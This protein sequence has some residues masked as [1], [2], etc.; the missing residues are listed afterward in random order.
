VL[1]LFHETPK[2]MSCVCIFSA[3]V[4]SC[5]QKCCSVFKNVLQKSSTWYRIKERNRVP[6]QYWKCWLVKLLFKTLKKYIR[7]LAKM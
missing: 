1:T 6:T 3:H 4:M 5:S 7:N 2:F